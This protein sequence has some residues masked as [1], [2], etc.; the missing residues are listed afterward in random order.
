MHAIQV[1]SAA[2]SR[3][4][5]VSLE[6]AAKEKKTLTVLRQNLTESSGGT[7]TWKAVKKN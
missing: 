1:W 3:Q 2:S 4:S 5:S 7:K 6:S